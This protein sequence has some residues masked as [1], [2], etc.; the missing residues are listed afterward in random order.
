MPR[1][2]V[3][4][5][6]GR[7]AKCGSRQGL[8]AKPWLLLAFIGLLQ[9]AAALA[10][11]AQ[12]D[13]PF[14]W[15]QASHPGEGVKGAIETTAGQLLSVRTEVTSDA[16]EIVCF[17][18]TDG[19]V[20]WS[21]AGVVAS[22]RD[23]KV[24]LGDAA[25]VQ[26]RE[27]DV[28]CSYRHIHANGRP[29][30][31]YS[32]AI[33]I[34]R[35]SDAGASWHLHSTVASCKG[36]R[37]GLWSSFVLQKR[38][39]TLQCYFDDER[40]PWLHGY[41]RHQWLTMKSYDARSGKWTRPVTV[42][43][44]HNPKHLSRDGMPSAVELPDGKLLCVFESVHVTLPHSG[45]LFSVTS[46]DGGRSWSW[47]SR[48]RSV[49]YAARKRAYNALAP[50]LVQLTSGTLVCVFVT[51]EERESP[52]V[53][54]TAKLDEDVKAV[55][56]FDQGRSW[57]K[58]PQTLSAEHPCYLPGIVELRQGERCGQV[59]VQYASCGQSVCKSGR[60]VIPAP[61]KD[62]ADKAAKKKKRP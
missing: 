40:T 21:R 60:L 35:S 5:P 7:A 32:Y 24:D 22:D 26:L 12:A 3:S 41:Q 36:A 53:A 14:Q 1:E 13:Y 38:D 59:L 27:G 2:T 39:G 34:A 17:R 10:H 44:A 16:V 47:R 62:N 18:S 55:Y 56:S 42:S 61:E 30:K 43:R 19:G 8:C 52:D 28:L 15:E 6:I 46:K 57:S 51:D 50:W 33:E 48:E 58:Q 29:E 45:I 31:E 11:A 37:G 25:L 23:K 49:V 4:A 20:N 54:A 9:C